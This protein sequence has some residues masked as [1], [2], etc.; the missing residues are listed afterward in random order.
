MQLSPLPHR[1]ARFMNF[2]IIRISYLYFC[3]GDYEFKKILKF[4]ANLL[5]DYS[6]EERVWGKSPPS[7]NYAFFL[8]PIDEICAFPAIFD[9]ILFFIAIL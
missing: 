5:K 6:K 4:T 3:K 7:T 9:E 8:Q 1:K 2:E